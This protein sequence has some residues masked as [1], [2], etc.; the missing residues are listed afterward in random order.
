MTLPD[1]ATLPPAAPALLGR[2]GPAAWAIL[3]Q[4][5]FAGANFLMNVLLARWLGADAYGALAV[6][7]ATLFLLGAMHMALLGEPLLVF[8]AGRFAE[9]R[10]AYLAAILAGHWAVSGVVLVAMVVAGALFAMGE[11]RE[12]AVALIGLGLASPFIL[13]QWLTRRICYLTRQPHAA[14]LAGAAYLALMLGG[15]VA[16]RQGGWVSLPS[17]L[18]VMGAASAVTG[19]ALVLLIRPGWSSLDRLLLREAASAH[20]GYGRWSMATNAAIFSSGQAFYLLAAMLI[21]LEA[22][23]LLR[24]MMNLVTPMHLVSAAAATLLVP[25][26]VRAPTPEAVR[27]RTRAVLALLC[28]AAAGYWLILGLAQGPLFEIVYGGQYRP[29]GA[30]VWILGATLVTGAASDVAAAAL[31]ARERPDL[32]FA[33][34]AGAAVFA[35][36]GGTALILLLGMTGTVLSMAISGA[37]GAAGL[38]I[39]LSRRR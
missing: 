35:L 21:S 18:V 24:A 1:D 16:L 11:S 25:A 28:A 32:V 33:A 9:R 36:A 5:F 27:S 23:A 10:G 19:L 4:A 7:L 39:F 8:G 20:A 15:L 3:D 22:S 2:F 34:F 13:L 17:A 30:L 12:L 29:R 38:A 14:A 31:R 6:G 26:L 37:A